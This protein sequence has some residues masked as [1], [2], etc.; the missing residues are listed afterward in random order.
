MNE[1][2]SQRNAP[3]GPGALWPPHRE[4]RRHGAPVLPQGTG[5]V[6]VPGSSHEVAPSAGRGSCIESR[7]IGWGP[8]TNPCG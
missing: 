3:V 2:F 4:H 7:Y 5:S 6:V 1:Q 8:D